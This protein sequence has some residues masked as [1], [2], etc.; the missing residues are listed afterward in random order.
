MAAGASPAP[1]ARSP[2][3]PEGVASQLICRVRPCEKPSPLVSVLEGQARVEVCPEKGH[4]GEPLRFDKVLGSRGAAEQDEMFDVVRPA[5]AS[6]FNGNSCTVV[7]YGG[8][9]SGKS[10][11]LSGFFMHTPLHGLA[12]RAIQLIAELTDVANPQGVPAVEASFFEIQQD[13]VSDLLPRSCPRVTMRETSQPPFVVMDPNLTTHRCDGAPGHNRLLDTYFTGLEHK[14][15]GSHTCFQITFVQPNGHRSYL[16]F[17]EMAWP[18][19]QAHVAAAVAPTAAGRSAGVS[20]AT[21]PQPPGSAQ[22]RMGTALE[23]VVQWKLTGAGAAPYRAS[24]LTTLLKPCFEGASL[25]YF[26]YC[27]RLEQIQL[28]YLAQAAPLLAKLHMW[29]RTRGSNAASVP[30]APV[31]NPQRQG[32]PPPVVPPLRLNSNGSGVLD[33]APLATGDNASVGSSSISPSCVSSPHN[34]QNHHAGACGGGNVEVTS[35]QFAVSNCSKPP[36]STPPALQPPQRADVQQQPNAATVELRGMHRCSELIQ[37]KQRAVELLRADAFRSEAA[38]RDLASDL[39]VLRIRREAKDENG[40]NEQETNLKLV[41]EKI[42]RSLKTTHD[43][44]RRIDDDLEVLSQFCGCGTV[45]PLYDSYD[46]KEEDLDRMLVHAALDA[47]GFANAQEDGTSPEIVMSTM[48]AASAGPP[49]VPPLRMPTGDHAVYAPTIIVPQLP[50]NKLPQE[51][52]KVPSNLAQVNFHGGQESG[53]SPSSSSFDS[54][55]DEAALQRGGSLGGTTVSVSSPAIGGIASSPNVPAM[56]MGAPKVLGPGV[57][58]CVTHGVAPSPGVLSLPKTP[59][60]PTGFMEPFGVATA[61]P[62]VPVV[63]AS[64]SSLTSSQGG[65]INAGQWRYEAG[66][67]PRRTGSSASVAAAGRESMDGEG[68]QQPLPPRSPDM[69][70][71]TAGWRVFG[72]A[73][74][75]PVAATSHQGATMGPRQLSATDV[76]SPSRVDAWVDHGVH[77]RKSHSTTSLR[78]LGVRAGATVTATAVQAANAVA[79][80]ASPMLGQRTERESSGCPS[81]CSLTGTSAGGS[82]PS[83]PMPP[84]RAATAMMPARSGGVVTRTVGPRATTPAARLAP[85]LAVSSTSVAEQRVR[86]SPTLPSR[87]ASTASPPLRLERCQSGAAAAPTQ[88]VTRCCSKQPSPERQR[89]V[90]TSSQSPLRPVWASGNP[91][92]AGSNASP[93]P[94]VG[95]SAAW[96]G[97]T[98]SM[99][100]PAP[101]ASAPALGVTAQQPSNKT[102]RAWSVAG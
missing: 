47:R 95:H 68:R 10:Y 15:K 20:A 85:G 91:A 3:A 64:G 36:N 53:H 59:P 45:P 65:G 8:P 79:T 57:N 97:S 88:K 93:K 75:S 90:H 37:V 21:T 54:S 27:L 30:T 74:A 40:P 4:P 31:V 18:R 48:P 5:V 58:A 62:G 82:V 26:I 42:C 70:Q 98:P 1:G 49:T 29:L 60:Q 94:L 67:P 96:P 14:R 35:A 102:P 6:C 19:Q 17:V 77:V 25:L 50:L 13:V 87:H 41:Y 56:W 7:A 89:G 32:P 44:I 76:S 12:P 28:S 84:K 22:E 81:R 80:Q 66:Q 52:G 100:T 92:V 55:R 23:Q 34:V 73:A 43:H 38:L 72:S 71:S 46:V 39:R 11:T 2:A 101:T 24:F 33:V 78:S 83:P 16:R 61:V 99:P 9:Q 69:R 86:G 51:Q 63:Y